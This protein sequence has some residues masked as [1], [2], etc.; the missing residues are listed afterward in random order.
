MLMQQQLG[1]SLVEVIKHWTNGW[2]DDNLHKNVLNKS[3]AEKNKRK[4]EG[5]T[6]MGHLDLLIFSS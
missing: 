6:K 1:Y 4:F 5:D 2:M 3:M